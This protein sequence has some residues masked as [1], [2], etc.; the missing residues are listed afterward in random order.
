MTDRQLDQLEYEQHVVEEQ[1]GA[2][3]ERVTKEL[4]RTVPLF[5]A[6]PLIGLAMI[7]LVMS[8]E[9]ALV[10]RNSAAVMVSALLVAAILIVT[11]MVLFAF[12]PDEYA[13]HLGDLERRLSEIIPQ[14][15]TEESRQGDE[16]KISLD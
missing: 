2:R 16:K 3:R 15:R 5:A 1:I 12:K 4:R 6:P 9:T 13:A 7:V 14:R 8:G 11:P 10:V